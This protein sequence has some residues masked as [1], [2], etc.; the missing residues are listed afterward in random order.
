EGSVKFFDGGTS[1][2]L[3]GT[4]IGAAQPVNTTTS[5]ATVNTAA[6]TGDNHTIRACYQGT[7]NYQASGDSVGQLVNAAATSTS[8]ATSGSPSTYGDSVTFTTT[9]TTSSPS[10]P[11]G[12]GSV[13]FFDGGTS[14]AL[15]GTQIGAAQPVNTTTGL[16]SVNPPALT[17]THLPYPALF[18]CTV[19][20][21]A[22]GD[23][24]GQL[25]NAAATS[26]SVAT[27]GSPST[28]GDSVTFTEIRRASCR[29]GGVGEG[30]VTSV[31]GGTSCALPG[32]QIGAAQPVTTTTGV[33]Q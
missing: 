30:G 28:Y 8:V 27:S 11:V 12:E 25:V 10:A 4:Q 15:P 29:E 16:A 13:K 17:G 1:C 21:Q 19:N 22:S 24:V 7:V 6:L 31:D 9:V 2:A 32:H 3:P 23:S 26:T 5:V 18:R 14:C 20:Y 33:A